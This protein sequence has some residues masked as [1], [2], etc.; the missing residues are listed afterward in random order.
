MS[1]LYITGKVLHENGP[2]GE[3]RPVSGA[4]VEIL[5]GDDQIRGTDLILLATTDSNGEFSGL[6]TEWRTMVLNT[7]PDP[8][9]PWKTMQV[10]EPD[11]LEKMALR[12]RIRQTT[13]QGVKVGTLPVQYVDDITPI[14][15]LVVDWGPPGQSALGSVNGIACSSPM[16]LLERGMEALNARCA[17]V[18]MEAFGQ[19]GEPYLELTAPT[20]RQ[21]RLAAS[22]NVKPDDVLRIRALLLSND[23]AAASDGLDSFWLSLV[24]ASIVFSPVTGQAGASFGLALLRFLQSGYRVQ[25]VGNASVSLNGTGVSIRLEHPGVNALQSTVETR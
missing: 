24:V 8:E 16:E 25:S 15:P 1:Q 20:A 7:V 23:A 22:M 13:A 19:A 17:E 2:W 14:A 18:R 10:E 6:T 12:A 11:P 21:Q 3:N 4:R 9:M 5:S